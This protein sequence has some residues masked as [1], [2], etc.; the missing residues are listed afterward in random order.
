[1][2]V[3]APRIEIGN[4]NDFV[5]EHRYQPLLSANPVEQLEETQQGIELVENNNETLMI[6]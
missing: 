1:M 4:S 3:V 6:F 2:A 5:V